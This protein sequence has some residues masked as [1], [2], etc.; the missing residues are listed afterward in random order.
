M[1]WTAVAVAHTVEMA[2]ALIT[3][4][5][6]RAGNPAPDFDGHAS[7]AQKTLGRVMERYE[8][9]R[10]SLDWLRSLLRYRTG[11]RRRK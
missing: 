8:G 2:K 9:R 7:P 1:G 4:T 6:L 11:Q 3:A 10:I 5:V